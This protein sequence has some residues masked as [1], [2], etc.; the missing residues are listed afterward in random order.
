M[1]TLVKR[2]RRADAN[3][4]DGVSFDVDAG[5]LFCLLGPNGAGK[6]TALSILT[7]SL[8]PTAGTAWVAGHDVA[9]DPAVVRRHVGVVFQGPSLDVNLTA[10]ENIRVHAVLYGLY[11]WRPSVRLMARAYHRQ[12]EQ[13]AGVLGTEGVLGRPVRTLSGG[14]RRKLEIVRALM[15][16]PSVLFLDEPT[17]GLDPESRRNLWR[18][19]DEVRR[20]RGTTVFFS[21]HYLT[22]AEPAGKLCIL[23]RGRVLEMGSPADVRAR[24]AQASTVPLEEAYLELL[25]REGL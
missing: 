7:T 6:S 13:L 16:D 2:Y 18:Y 11:P 23:A 15:H 19:L 1:R 4:L 8:L 9:H 17:V 10:E 12:L 14:T 5:E 25:E 22:E 20:T 21:T 3:A 24:H